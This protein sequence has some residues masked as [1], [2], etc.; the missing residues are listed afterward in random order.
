MP[1]T[2]AGAVAERRRGA[3]R[4]GAGRASRPRGL[5]RLPA[6]DRA[7]RADF[8]RFLLEQRAAG[9]TV[10]G[11]GAAAK[12]N[13]L[14]NYC[15][16][17]GNELIRFVADASPHKQGRFLPGSHIPVV[18]PERIDE[19]KPDFIIIFPWN[20]R[21][22][23][24]GQLGMRVLGRAVRHRDSRASD[25]VSRFLVTGAS[26]FIG[27][28]IVRR[29]AEDGHEAS[30]SRADLL[31]GGP[32]RPRRR[33]AP[34]HCIHAAWYTNH[35]DYLTHEVNR[36][37]VAASLRLADAFRRGRFVGLGTCLEYD[38]APR[39]A[40]RGGSHAASPETL[41]ARCKL[42][43][44]EAL[45]RRGR[46]FAWARMFFVYGPGDRAG[47]LIPG[48]LER[49]RARRARPGRPTAGF[50]ATISTS[51]ISP[52]RSCGSRLSDVRGAI[53]TGTGEAPTLSDIFA[54]GAAAFG[55]P[56]LAPSQCRDRWPA[57]A[58]PGRPDALP[59]RV[60][61]PQ[62]RDIATGL[63]DLVGM[64][65]A[66]AR[67]GYAGYSRDFC[68]PGDR[69]RFAAYARLKGVPIEY[70]E[71]GACLRPRLCHLQQRPARLGRAQAPR[72][73]SPQARVRADRRL[74]HRDGPARRAA[75]GQRRGGCSA[76][77][78]ACRPISAEP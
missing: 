28:A 14:L 24:I 44:F 49:F 3:R 30:P 55:R 65:L 62:A 48:M 73:R 33:P 45:E 21:D 8:L 52:A 11:Y 59:R 20:L 76:P 74:F 12:G 67:I 7:I 39:R 36:D 35:A 50:A 13:T 32:A 26:G 77:T 19:E 47:R 64:R 9:E 18:A 66:D 51:T 25:L 27:S 42:E 29:L 23:I 57:A 46:D 70:A 41:Y 31:A 43:L 16:I 68:A 34:R 6:A 75:Q 61:D 72:G 17:K 40:V 71:L 22:E 1:R 38:F 54:A 10:A 5:R 15:G 4:R 37:W 2:T 60:G 56:E 78:A 69:R 58:D 53:N 63:R